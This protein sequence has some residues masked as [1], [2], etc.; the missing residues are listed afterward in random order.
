M[1][2]HSFHSLSQ[3]LYVRESNPLLVHAHNSHNEPRACNISIDSSVLATQ[4]CICIKTGDS[5]SQK[6]RLNRDTTKATDV[7]K[8]ETRNK[9]KSSQ[10]HNNNFLLYWCRDQD[11]QGEHNWML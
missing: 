7:V 5:H 8:I 11:L 3:E 10:R 6:Q 1:L 4:V 9:I 2:N